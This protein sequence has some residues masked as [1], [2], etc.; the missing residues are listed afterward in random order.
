MKIVVTI[1]G[2]SVEVKAVDWK[3][4]AWADYEYF[5]DEARVAA[6]RDDLH[7]R[8]RFLRAALGNLFSH[9]DGFVRRIHK[10]LRKN[11]PEFAYHTASTR[12]C[13]LVGMIRDVRCHAK[14]TLGQ[15]IPFADLRLKPLRDI[16]AHPS[17]TKGNHRGGTRGEYRE[18]D[19]YELTPE[20]LRADGNNIGRF[21]DELVRVY[22]HERFPDTAKTVAEFTKAM[23]G[24]K[25]APRRM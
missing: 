3:S 16:I 11:H 19:L 15:P 14:E 17:I 12:D 2:A 20:L 9:R 6:D 4:D 13:T 1:D 5:L 10:T 18:V 22:G 23:S 24:S 7:G 25:Q 8:N 21:L